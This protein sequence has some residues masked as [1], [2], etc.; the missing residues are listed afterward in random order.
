MSG[1]P[2]QFEALRADSLPLPPPVK[3]RYLHKPVACAVRTDSWD[4]IGPV[5]RMAHATRIIFRDMQLPPPAK[6][7]GDSYIDRFARL[8][9]YSIFNRAKKLNLSFQLWL[10]V[11]RAGQPDERLSQ[12]RVDDI[13][14]HALNKVGGSIG[15]TARQIGRGHG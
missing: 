10:L 11:A 4:V 12:R 6:G 7:R 5:V 14:R 8:S 15:D 2:A 13:V 3:H 9:T 1:C